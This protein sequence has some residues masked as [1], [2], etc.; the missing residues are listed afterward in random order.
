MVY[1]ATGASVAL[2]VQG[3][4]W[5]MY[6]RTVQLGVIRRGQKAV[7][8]FI[9]RCAPGSQLHIVGADYDA[10]RVS[11]RFSTLNKMEISVSVETKDIPEGAFD[12]P[13]VIHTSGGSLGSMSTRLQGRVLKRLEVDNR[14]I[15][16]HG[17]SDGDTMNG[18]F[19]LYA[20]Y[21]GNITVQEVVSSNPA[22]LE[23]RRVK[24]SEK[25]SVTME[26]RYRLSDAEAEVDTFV[27]EKI[28]VK[29]KVDDSFYSEEVLVLGLVK[30][31][32]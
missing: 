14:R 2:V 26:I 31:K 1:L 28:T 6:P 22:R 21:G 30:G 19:K 17:F 3:K 8:N 25:D 7:K 29:A 11:V 24:S 20:P 18:R 32:S 16:L 9:V 5:E 23:V 15:I 12:I 10:E 27:N 4:V 13:L